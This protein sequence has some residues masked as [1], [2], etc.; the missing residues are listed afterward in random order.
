M[1]K[2][3]ETKIKIPALKIPAFKFPK[4]KLSLNDFL[5][6][7]KTYTPI[8]LVLLIIAS[9]LLGATTTKLSMSDQTE[10]SGKDA[11]AI[12]G[13]PDAPGQPAAGTKVDVEIGH[14][15]VLGDKNAKITVV[16]FSDFQCPFCKQWVD[17]TKEK[18]IKDYVDTGKIKFAFRQYP[19]PQ[20]HPNAQKAAEASECANDQDK[21]WDYHDLLFKEQA[22]WAS[23]PDPVAQFSTY[24]GQVGLE[25]GAFDSCMSSGKFADQVAEDIAAGTAAGVSGTPTFFINGISLVG[26]QP[27]DSF[28]TAI[29]TELAK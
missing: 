1:A 7:S 23:L 11:K 4:L 22:T 14:L 16:E 8:L 6:D 27:Y 18:L 13:T 25:S 15:P 24:A 19:I 29:D 17:Q 12:P 5:Q 3:S 10:S 21:F 28:K 2:T 9:F 26:A 20:L